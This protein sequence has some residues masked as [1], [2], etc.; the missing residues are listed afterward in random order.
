MSFMTSD[1]IEW[2]KRI[3]KKFGTKAWWLLLFVSMKA[4]VGRIV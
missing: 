1:R 2:R 4:Q 3:H